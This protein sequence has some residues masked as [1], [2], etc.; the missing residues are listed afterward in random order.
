MVQQLKVYLLGLDF[1]AEAQ[2]IADQVNGSTPDLR[3]ERAEL[4]DVTAQI[5]NGLKAI[6]TG[7]DIPE[8]RD[9]MDRLRVRK[10]ELEDIIGRRTARRKAVDPKDIVRLFE[11]SVEKWDTNLP[12]IIKQH[13]GK[14]YAH[15]D[16]S[17]AVNVGVH[18]NGCGGRT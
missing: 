9:E 17:C 10:A 6:L 1:E 13:V 18:L 16:G 15:T 5:N 2:R 11:E 12:T 8:L 7:M 3:A 14:I 4:A